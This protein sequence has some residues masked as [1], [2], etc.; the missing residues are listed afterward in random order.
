MLIYK[1][2]AFSLGRLAQILE[3]PSRAPPNVVANLAQ[4]AS[5]AAA[6]SQACLLELY[7]EFQDERGIF[8]PHSDH[9]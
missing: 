8:F 9:T 6:S 2:D 7:T 4:S 5:A 1:N 3:L